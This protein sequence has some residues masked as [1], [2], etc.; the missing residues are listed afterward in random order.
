MNNQEC[1]FCKIIEK[2]IP[3]TVVAENDLVIAIK[4]IAPKAPLHYLLIP[5]IHVQDLAA[6]KPGD[7]EYS[8]AMMLMAQELSHKLSGS[9]AFRLIVN[10]GADVGQSV[11]HLHAHFLSG[12]KMSDF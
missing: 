6:L 8:S 3:A 1:I 11:F 4:D 2:K 5:K 7:I 12:K 9:Q 10:N